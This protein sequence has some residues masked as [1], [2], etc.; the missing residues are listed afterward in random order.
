MIV[1]EANKDK[2]ESSINIIGKDED[3][4]T[5][6]VDGGEWQG[7]DGTGNQADGDTKLFK[8]TPYDTKLTVASSENL[9]LLTGDVFMTDGS[10]TPAT[11]TPYKL[12]TTDI[13]SV[14]KLD[15]QTEYYQKSYP[16]PAITD[17]GTRFA[18]KF[19]WNHSEL[20]RPQQWKFS[21]CWRHAW[22]S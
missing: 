5:I 1:D 15:V 19:D 17:L 20:K 10:E 12:V 13:E 18:P 16:R 8:Q 7:T 4:N 3:A 21:D 22:R 14:G 2:T 9:E 6:T 11:Q